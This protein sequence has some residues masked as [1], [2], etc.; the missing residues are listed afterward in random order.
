LTDAVIATL[1]RDDLCENTEGE[2]HSDDFVA[3][4]LVALDT[5]LQARAALASSGEAAPTGRLFRAVRAVIRDGIDAPGVY[6]E[7][8]LAFY[9]QRDS[10]EADGWVWECANCDRPVPPMGMCETCGVFGVM[11][12][13]EQLRSSGEAAPVDGLDPEWRAWAAREEADDGR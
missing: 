12:L 2:H 1:R 9:E 4:F 13:A 5:E 3:G 8:H 10:G 7:L 6:D 11:R